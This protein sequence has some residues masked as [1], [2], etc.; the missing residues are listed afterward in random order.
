MSKFSFASAFLK[1]KTHL[2]H[3][4]KLVSY[5]TNLRN[6]IRTIA[7]VADRTNGDM[8]LRLS[9]NLLTNTTSVKNVTTI[10]D[11]LD[12]TFAAATISCQELGAIS[13]LFPISS[14][15]TDDSANQIVD[16]KTRHSLAMDSVLAR[17]K[18]TL[19]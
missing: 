12:S 2:E 10:H 14:E 16:L 15:K 19:L 8:I 18:D 6:S 17:L 5:Y 1:W 13:L 9:E 4:A 7:I 11:C 3:N